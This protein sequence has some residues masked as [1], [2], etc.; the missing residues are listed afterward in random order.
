MVLGARVDVRTSVVM[1]G[2]PRQGCLAFALLD[3]LTQDMIDRTWP[4]IIITGLQCDCACVR[5]CHYPI[6]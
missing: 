4:H 1:G 3:L 6:T 2:G 5:Q